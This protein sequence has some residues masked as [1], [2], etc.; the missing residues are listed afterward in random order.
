MF[1]DFS[2]RQQCPSVWLPQFCPIVRF[3]ATE[4]RAWGRFA[5]AFSV[6][7]S[8]GWAVHGE[9]GKRAALAPNDRTFAFQKLG[10]VAA[11]VLLA[12]SLVRDADL[13]LARGVHM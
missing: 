6:T 12:G 2:F 1:P 13:R 5:S 11:V 9:M 3:F 10:G 8:F 7:P 4:G